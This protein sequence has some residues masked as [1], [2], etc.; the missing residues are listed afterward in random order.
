MFEYPY[1]NSLVLDIH[2]NILVIDINNL[3]IYTI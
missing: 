2:V 3:D 1:T